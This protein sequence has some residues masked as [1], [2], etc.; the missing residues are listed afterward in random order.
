MKTQTL[1]GSLLAIQVVLAL[2]LFIGNQRAGE[3]PSPQHLLS[4]ATSDIARIV[5]TASAQQTTL[6]LAGD[7]WQLPTMQLPAN[8]SRIRTLL[9]S[10]SG[11]QTRWPVVNSSSGRQR[12]AVA[13]DNYQR[14]LQF[15]DGDILLGEYYFGTSPGFRQ[16]HGRRA[17]EDAVYALAFNSVDLPIDSND[18][19]DKTLL[20][21]D[22]P[23]RIAGPDFTLTRE[24]ETWQ[25]S[26]TTT[27]ALNTAAA[28][29][30]CGYAQ[31]HAGK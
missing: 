22:M 20:A 3:Q 16:T 8:Q 7:K 15:Y 14:K 5:I 30:Q 28:L 1:L 13:D 23:T 17:G 12:F 25:L 6:A 21:V 4:F 10:L 31:C 19:L 29:Y 2:S 26:D 9:D 24:Q 11:L 27:E 18:W